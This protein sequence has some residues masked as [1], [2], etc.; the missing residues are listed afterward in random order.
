MTW[1]TPTRSGP[2]RL[3]PVRLG[4]LPLETQR[5]RPLSRLGEPTEWLENNNWFFAGIVGV[6]AVLTVFALVVH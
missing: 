6:L 3:C 4:V 5:E 2:C 1:P